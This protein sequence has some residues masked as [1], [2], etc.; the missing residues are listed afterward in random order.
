MEGR[1]RWRTCVRSNRESMMQEKSIQA[2]GAESPRSD[3][4]VGGGRNSA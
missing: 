4:L 1:M 2:G 3:A